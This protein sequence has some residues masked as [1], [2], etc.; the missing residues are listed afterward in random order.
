MFYDSPNLYLLGESYAIK[1]GPIIN[2]TFGSWSHKTGLT[3]KTP[4]ILE[5][6]KNLNGVEIRDSVLPYSKISQ[7]KYDSEGNV[8]SSGGIF[9]VYHPTSQKI[10]VI[11]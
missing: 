3:I 11:N 1:R 2:R 8:I 7:P 4:N 9:Q 10:V 6:R 5:R